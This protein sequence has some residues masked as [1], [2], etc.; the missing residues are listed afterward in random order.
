M[1]TEYPVNT[2][3][4]N[5]AF[6]IHHFEEF[7]NNKNSEIAFINLSDDFMDHDEQGGPAIGPLKAKEMMEG[8]YKMMPDLHVIIEDIIA[9]NDKVMVRNIWTGTNL[10]GKKFQF[11]GFVQWKLKDGKIIERWATVTQPYQIEKEDTEW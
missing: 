11:K 5:K 4:Y 2:P 1:K 10:Q 3:E 9:E 6:V 8:M 7:V